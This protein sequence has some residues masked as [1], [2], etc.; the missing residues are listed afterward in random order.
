[1][2]PVYRLSISESG[3]GQHN[4]PI[5]KEFLSK[6]RSA[7]YY[8]ELMMIAENF[9]LILKSE[10]TT[11][12]KRNA[13]RHL[14][15]MLQTRN[16]FKTLAALDFRLPQF[17]VHCLQDSDFK[18]RLEAVE[19]F[20]FI[21]QGCVQPVLP[22]LP[23]VTKDYRSLGIIN[24]FSIAKKETHETTKNFEKYA[25]M[26]NSV[27]LSLQMLSG[28]FESPM[29]I[30][31]VVRLIKFKS[32]PYETKEAAV[33]ILTSVLSGNEK[34]QLS[35]LS[36]ITDTVSTLCK[37]LV[38]STKTA[39]K[40]SGKTLATVLK[41]LLSELLVNAR[42]YIL[43][44]FK[45]TP[46]AEALLKEQGI[47]LP[48]RVTLQ[49]LAGFKGSPVPDANIS[50]LVQNLK[51]WLVHEKSPATLSIK[52][53]EIISTSFQY[54]RDSIDLQWDL[55]DIKSDSSSFIPKTLS[56]LKS[57]KEK[58]KTALLFLEWS[59][60]SDLDCGWFKSEANVNWLISKASSAIQSAGS[61]YQIFYLEEETMLLQR[62][63][64]RLLAKE[65]VNI[66]LG[67]LKF[68]QRFA[69]Q[70]ISQYSRLGEVISNHTEPLHVLEF[71]PKASEIRLAAF[72]NL[73]QL[74]NLQ[75]QM[76]ES[77]F[78]GVLVEYFLNDYRVL[79]VRFSKLSLEFLPFRE[80]PPVRSEGINIVMII[81]K[82][83]NRC[84]V[85]YDDLLL[86]LQRFKTVQN[87]IMN[88][89]S[90]NLVLQATALELVQAFIAS[91]DPQ[92]EYLLMQGNAKGILKD[93]CL[94]NKD[95]A[96]RF[97]VIATYCR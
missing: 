95:I 6:N 87:E 24:F 18:V 43:S 8:S 90:S 38:V 5:I 81:L 92:I 17:V 25:T 20:L 52:E 69:E 89:L 84:K 46:G 1:M 10:S 11:V 14:K 42:N 48:E 72:M 93:L 30:F 36:P 55:S 2:A 12:A 91:E 45:N 86:H 57:S 60:F 64:C 54:L 73:L 31:P 63:L 32:E 96:M 47:V 59:L 61:G 67:K 7:E 70:L 4:C 41:V 79:N 23:G 28:C 40:K 94:G 9:N 3:H 88:C 27:P 80:T 83:K 29:F 13:L 34:C 15:S 44:A 68:G 58:L 37:C 49:T 35:C 26:N 50:F 22:Q 74:N 85:V 16:E 97:P 51:N 78:I 39:D 76:L 75:T 53:Q 21:T 56:S 66:L 77:D 82:E 65:K 62:I 19:I 33:R 71:Y